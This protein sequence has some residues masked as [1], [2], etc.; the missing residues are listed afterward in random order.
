MKTDATNNSWQNR[1]NQTN[2]CKIKNIKSETKNACTHRIAGGK[3][4]IEAKKL[5]NE[6]ESENGGR[7]RNPLTYH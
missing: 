5:S 3:K 7:K 4:Q 6:I 2:E 1:G